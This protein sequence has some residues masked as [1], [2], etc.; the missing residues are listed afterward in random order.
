MH[1]ANA[2]GIPVLA[3]FGPT[4]AKRP[5]LWTQRPH[6]AKAALL[7]LSQAHLSTR[8]SRVHGEHYCDSIA[9]GDRD[10]LAEQTSRTRASNPA[11]KTGGW[12][13]TI[14]PCDTDHPTSDNAEVVFRAIHCFRGVCDSGLEFSG[15]LPSDTPTLPDRNCGRGLARTAANPCV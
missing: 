5:P 2:L 6:S 14:H 4:L 7:S 3:I 13:H 8:A 15:P 1:C 9:N 10:V 11:R 12:C